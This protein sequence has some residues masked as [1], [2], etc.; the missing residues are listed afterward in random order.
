[1]ISRK[2]GLALGALLGAS[3]A[4]PSVAL[5][6][7]FTFTSNDCTG[8]CGIQPGGT[9]SGTVTAT[10]S[11][12]TL[13]I[14]VSL[15]GL[16]FLAGNGA[17]I[18][19]SFAFSLAGVNGIT[20][21]G[22]TAAFSNSDGTQAGG[23]VMM[24]GAGTFE[25]FGYFVECNTC[26]PSAPDGSTL[27]FNVTATGLTGAQLLADL[28]TSNGGTGTAFFAADVLSTSGSTSGNTGVIDATRTVS[29]VPLPGALMLFGTVLA[30]GFGV[31][32][33]RKRRRGPVSVMA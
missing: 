5:A 7:S 16:D 24:D 14:S 2:H 22:A 13:T 21:S 6:D 30:G 26:S 31:S 25:T 20:I 8:G 1:M 11:G 9:N 4:L 28:Q 33:W 15:T 29:G 27:T 23:T 12:S 17:G 19:K 32:G 3:I 10:A 18:D